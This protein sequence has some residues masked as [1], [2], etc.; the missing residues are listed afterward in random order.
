MFAGTNWLGVVICVVAAI[1]VGFVWYS[2]PLFLNPWLAGIGKGP[3]FVQRP[4][5]MNYVITIVAAFVEALFLDT[6]FVRIMGATG[7]AAGALAGL[8]VWIG[9]V[10]TTSAA[11]A[12][13]GARGWKVWGI[14]AGNHMVTLVLMGIILSVMAQ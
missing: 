9:F 1:L 11:N 8:I 10:A 13:F 2:K 6:F 3:E 5:P 4:N 12:A 7:A 14:E